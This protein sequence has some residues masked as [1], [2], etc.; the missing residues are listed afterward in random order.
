MND[1][2]EAMGISKSSFYETFGNKQELFLSSIGH[3]ATTAL[4]DMVIALESDM[5][6]REVIAQVFLNTANRFIRKAEPMGCFL[7]I[8]LLN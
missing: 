1:L 3:Y 8:A 6:G 5:P 2:I 7:A 4:K